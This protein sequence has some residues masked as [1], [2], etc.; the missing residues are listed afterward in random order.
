MTYLNVNT[1]HLERKVL[2]ASFGELFRDQY[3]VERNRG[4][5]FGT[6]VIDFG[7]T[8]NGSTD[9]IKFDL[10]GSEFNSA[11]LSIV[12][13]FWPDFATDE[14]NHFYLSDTGR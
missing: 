7:A 12:M 4:T 13:K 8:L 10:A 3:R 9:Y 6:P 14:D 1:T 11:E 2:R 5:I